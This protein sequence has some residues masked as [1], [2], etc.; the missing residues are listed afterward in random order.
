METE[1]SGLLN[2]RRGWAVIFSA[3]SALTPVISNVFGVDLGSIV[4]HLDQAV[5][6]IFALVAGGFTLASAVK[7]NNKVLS[8]GGS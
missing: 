1:P 7:P 4:P 3:L 8:G 5:Q 6:A 2:M